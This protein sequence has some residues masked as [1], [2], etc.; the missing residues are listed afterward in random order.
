VFR[1]ITFVIF[2]IERIAKKYA[3]NGFAI[4]F[5]AELEMNMDKSKTTKH[6]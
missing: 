4:K 6:F 5:D 3:F 2:L 1:R